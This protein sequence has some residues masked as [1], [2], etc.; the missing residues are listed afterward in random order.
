M[1]IYK[2]HVKYL[3]ILNLLSA[4]VILCTIIYAWSVLRTLPENIWIPKGLDNP[5]L[6]EVNKN[7]IW[8]DIRLMVTTYL[9]FSVVTVYMEVT[10]F[11]A[12]SGFHKAQT[13]SVVN[14]CIC[15]IFAFTIIKTICAAHY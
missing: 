14:L 11:R 5:A 7:V 8:E 15:L 12:S 13:V 6:A 10:P 3:Q 9:V 4:L 1:K 2:K